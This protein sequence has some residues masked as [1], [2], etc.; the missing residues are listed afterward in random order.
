MMMSVRAKTTFNWK[1]CL[2]SSALISEDI[3]ECYET[4]SAVLVVIDRS[5]SGSLLNLPFLFV[6]D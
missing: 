5:Y 3:N 6:L 2:L 1:C 4:A